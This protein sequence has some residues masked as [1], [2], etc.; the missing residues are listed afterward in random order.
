[1]K[2]KV[3]NP[4][5]SSQMTEEIGVSAAAAAREDTE[6]VCVSP[7]HGPECVE[8]GSDA[9]ASS[10][11]LLNEVRRSE[12]EEDFDAYVVA[13]FGDPAVDAIREITEKPVVGIAEAAF[14]LSAFVGAKF[15]IVST[16]PRMRK[17][18][19]DRL[20]KAGATNR[21]ASLCTPNIPVL[22]FHEDLECSKRTM[23]EAARKCV[24]EDYAEVIILG[25]AGMTGFADI[26]SKEVGVPVLDTVMCGVKIAEILVDLGLKTSK[27]NTFQT[28]TPKI[29]K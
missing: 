8:G 28:P 15:S 21:L 9:V 10:F 2:I 20:A 16:L 19:E 27:A 6:I 24:E 23:I 4:N 22:A 13:C 29:H 25:C 12:E 3:I 26:V 5:T 1:M 7:P 17:E 11:H 14:Y 18:T